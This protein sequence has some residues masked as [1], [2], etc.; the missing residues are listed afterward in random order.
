[1]EKRVKILETMLVLTTA[2]LLFYLLG[3]QHRIWLLY[4]A[5]LIGGIGIF[6]PWLSAKVHAGWML[7]AK[8]LGW[9]NGHVLLSLIFFIFLSPLAWLARKF[10]AVNL[11]LRRNKAAG[12]YY[13]ARNHRYQPE[14]LKNTW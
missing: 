2:L 3:R 9:F 10:G 4:A 13:S 11:Q 7:V 12:S 1:M 6:F 14:D 5:L 8:A